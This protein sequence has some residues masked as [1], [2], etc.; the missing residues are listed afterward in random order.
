MGPRNAIGDVIDWTYSG[1]KLH[2]T[3]KPISVLMQLIEAF[4]AP[5]DLVLNPFAGSGST[6][7]AARMLGCHWLGIELDENYHRIATER[8]GQTVPRKPLTI[9]RTQPTVCAGAAL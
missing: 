8:L 6:L 3:Q 2:P 5:G 1:N 9:P 4:S 7:L